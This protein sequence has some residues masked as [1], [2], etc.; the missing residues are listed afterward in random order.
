MTAAEMADELVEQLRESMVAG[1]IGW[2]Y[3]P[4]LLK[5]VLDDGLWRE[6]IVGKTGELARFERFEDFVVSPPYAGLG[7][8][9]E[10][11][12]ALCRGD[13]KLLAAV[14]EATQRPA[15]IHARDVN[16]VHVTTRPEGNSA[17]RAVRQLRQRAE[18]GDEQVAALYAA[19]LAGEMS[20]HAAVVEAGLRKK[21]ATVPTDIDGLSRWIRRH[22]TPEQ[23]AELK[24]ALG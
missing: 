8:T 5:A 16:N 15:H 17:Q 14:D 18:A 13:R 11:I 1:R 6:R 22:Y 20:P 7:T 12:E 21:T 2:D 23:I 24:E 3:F 4:T 19:V 9:M 10:T